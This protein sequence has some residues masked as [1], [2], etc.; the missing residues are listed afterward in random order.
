MK[1]LLQSFEKGNTFLE[2]VPVPKIKPGH[3]LIKS[4]VSLI[5]YGTEK[6][7]VD[8]STANLIDKAKLQP[9]K[10][11]QTIDKLK[12]DGIISTYKAVKNKLQQPIQ[13][14]YCNAGVVI[15]I[16][17]DVTEF[18][19]GDR[20]LSNGPHS[21]IV[22]VSKNLATIIPDNVSIRHAP[23]A[24]LGAIGLQ[25]IRLAKPT[26][27][28]TFVV[29]GLGLI[30]LITAQLLKANG[31]NVLAI[32][33]N[34]ERSKLAE[35]LGIRVFTSLQ[36]KN[37]ISW[38]LR[39]TNQLGADG[40]LI[41]ASADTNEPII[42]ASEIC[43]KRGRIVLV[44]V[45]K[46]DL[47]RDLFYKKELSFQ[48]SCSYG[49]GRYDK[50]YEDFGNDYPIGFV[51]WTAKRNFAAV[52]QSI[53]KG[54]LLIDPLISH[55]YPFQDSIT[56]YDLLKNN[57]SSLGILLDY[58]KKV[59]VSNNFIFS[60]YKFKTKN[61]NSNKAVVGFI[62]AGNYASSFLIPM[63]TKNNCIL[64]SIASENGISAKLLANKFGF[65]SST[66][67]IN[68]IFKD[69]EINVVFIATRHDSHSELI[70][71]A[72]NY[73]KNV[74][75]EKPVCINSSEL[76]NL[77]K[78][79]SVDN[80]FLNSKNQ[81]DCIKPLLMVGFNRRFSPLI[82]EIKNKLTDLCGPKTII[83]TCNAGRLPD[84]HWIQDPL[85]GGGRAIGE[86]CHF[87][88]L[89]RY[90]IDSNIIEMN[91]D[92][93][94]SKL[95]HNTFNINMKFDNGSLATLHYFSNGTKSYPK[96]KIEIFSDDNIFVL[97]NFRKLT[98]WCGKKKSVRRLFNQDK[99]Q[100]NCVTEFINSLSSGETS[101][102][103]LSQIFEVQEFI[104]NTLKR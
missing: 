76:I 14:G 101:P 51:R 98:H 83:Y 25:G 73:G 45:T 12:N 3:L 99:G 36:S 94:N 29:I 2:E 71:K 22:C 24:V 63:L 6:M 10:V 41:T 90:L 78:L 70:Q 57:I 75:V 27:G 50:S 26:F 32:E 59:D 7:L 17:D 67:D 93:S 21:E 20:V 42:I 31:V 96:E 52:L 16:A 15:G 65:Q 13:L 87:I 30:G 103:P 49:P 104:L 1:A 79:F 48:V 33:P 89:I 61:N 18:K 62:G 74:F 4:E 91:I 44:G 55:E 39:E 100:K 28:E 8:F 68:N 97:D 82:K 72:I 43:R 64:K 69:K 38:C 58:P 53:S 37:I 34:I 11:S 40:V 9:D 92:D 88:D 54:S 80:S 77:K 46:L 60:E 56:A 95:P 5:S 102:I 66:S 19:L 81:K 86:A 35:S 85:I 23:F 47:S 84:E